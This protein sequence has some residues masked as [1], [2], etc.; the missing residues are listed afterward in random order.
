MLLPFRSC[1]CIPARLKFG[2][3]LGRQPQLGCWVAGS[4]ART[5]C[6]LAATCANVTG[7]QGPS[8]SRD[9]KS[10]WRVLLGRLWGSQCDRGGVLA[11]GD[12]AA[13]KEK[14]L[15]K[16]RL[17]LEGPRK[18]QD[19]DSQQQGVNWSLPQG[20]HLGPRLA[21]A[22]A[23]TPGGLWA[24]T[25][26]ASGGRRGWGWG[27]RRFIRTRPRCAAVCWVAKNWT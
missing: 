17:L 10:T 4:P 26:R 23:G 3:A 2:S 18:V 11:G 20:P 21:A 15:M 7:C 24:N 8:W 22:P 12:P 9:L 5:Q 19:P 1:D 13:L 14:S 25:A 6:H 27:A 16:A